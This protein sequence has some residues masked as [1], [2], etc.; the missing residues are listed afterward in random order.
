MKLRAIDRRP[1]QSLHV[2]LDAATHD[3]LVA[4]REYAGTQGQHFTDLKQLLAEIVRAFVDE[5]DKEFSRWYR[6]RTLPTTGP[7]STVN[8]GRSE[9]THPLSVDPRTAAGRGQGA[10]E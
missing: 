5:G 10:V 6:A 7:S 9:R 3:K 8:G 1:R 2:T 4:Y